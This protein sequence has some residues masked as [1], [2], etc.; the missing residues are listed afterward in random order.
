METIKEALKQNNEPKEEA[1]EV[2]EEK[3]PET[4]EPEEKPS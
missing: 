1:S 3:I 2:H 4:A